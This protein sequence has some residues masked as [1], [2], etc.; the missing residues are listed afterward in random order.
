MLFKIYQRDIFMEIIVERNVPNF[1]ITTM[2]GDGSKD[3]SV[4]LN[5]MQESVLHYFYIH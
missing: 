3:L 4:S 2:S 5:I 1:K